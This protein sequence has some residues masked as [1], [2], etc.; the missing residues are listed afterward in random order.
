MHIR[1]MVL[2][3]A[4]LCA[5]PATLAAQDPS[6]RGDTFDLA[7]AVAVAR[8]AN[9][10]V[11]SAAAGVDAATARIRP[12]GALPD[13]TLTLGAMNYMLPSLSAARDPLSMNQVTVMQMLPV[14]GTLG[15]RRTVARFDSTRVAYR[16]DAVVLEV[17]REARSRYWDLYHIDRAR[18]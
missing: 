7:R 18:Q 2:A 8:V 16:R 4:A 6:A 9:P 1:I 13:P 11:T 17:E 14:N 3:V 12:A 5:A 10:R 15:L